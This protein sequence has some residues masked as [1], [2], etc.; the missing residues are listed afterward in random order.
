MIKN[1]FFIAVFI[2]AYFVSTAQ[3][4]I[5]NGNFEQ[6]QGVG[7]NTEEPVG[8]NS[9][10]TGGGNATTGPQTCFRA[11]SP[12]TGTYCAR[13]KSGSTFGIVVNGSLT[14]GKV[15]APSLSKSDG[16]IRTIPTDTSYRMEFTGRPDSLVFWLKY[17]PG[18]SDRVRLEARLHVGFA[19]APEAP[20]NN[21]HPDS[22]QN[23]IARAQFLS[24]NATI[25][26]W[27]RFSVPFVYVDARTPQYILIT[28]T[29]S[30]DQNGGNSNSEMFIDDIEAVYNPIVGAVNNSSTFYVSNTTG[31]AI[32]VPFTL[33]ETY[34]AGNTVTAQL[35]D[36][37]GSFANP[38]NIGSITATASGTINATIPAGTPSGTGYKIR[39]VSSN[40]AR[41][42]SNVSGNISVSID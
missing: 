22:T 31:T 34:N 29:P 32:N 27:T 25:S 4:A 38:V 14:T 18:G 23:I 5:R 33:I 21:N 13:V 40:P 6:W 12:N 3:T 37:S 20:S 36:A 11:T 8:W 41:I 9:N 28:M 16:Y 24:N 1:F 26:S 35:S 10:K 19:Y 42:S 17:T 7:S 2:A 39:V 15:E 30:H